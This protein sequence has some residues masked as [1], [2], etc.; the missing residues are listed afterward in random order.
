MSYDKAMEGQVKAKVT[1]RIQHA[2]SRPA[3]PAKGYSSSLSPPPVIKP[4][5]KVNSSAAIGSRKLTSA[6]TT[7]NSNRGSSIRTAA[8]AP[9][10]PRAPSPFKSSSQ[11][12]R[13]NTTTNASPVPSPNVIKA[14]VSG[15]ARPASVLG[16][17]TSS[18]VAPDS[19]ARA[20]TASP[21]NPSSLAQQER[22]RRGSVSSTLT[23]PP[24]NAYSPT[25]SPGRGGEWKDF[26]S[27]EV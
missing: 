4:K 12:S 15:S 2:P 10:Y 23:A 17:P 16:F 3:S 5:A 26:N 21:G 14:K 20:Y 22:R 18:S 25:T 9:S 24:F 8:T 1:S 19:R 6:T 7:V 13:V 27:G 11:Q